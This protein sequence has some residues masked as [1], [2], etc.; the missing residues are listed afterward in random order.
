MFV[1][2]ADVLQ[3]LTTLHL[4]V[5]DILSLELPFDESINRRYR[6]VHSLF[7]F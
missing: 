1:T 5:V 3:A 6:G 2:A 4:T 7:E